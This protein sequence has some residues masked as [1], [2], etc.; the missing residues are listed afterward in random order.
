[1]ND[2]LFTFNSDESLFAL[3]FGLNVT[4]AR[5]FFG[6]RLCKHFDEICQCWPLRFD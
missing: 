1:M 4:L 5:Q 3:A 2:I 6:S